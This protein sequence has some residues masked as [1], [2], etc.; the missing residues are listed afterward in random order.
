MYRYNGIVTH[1]ID[2]DTVVVNI[3]LGRGCLS[4]SYDLA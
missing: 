1:V 4:K 3:D 2:G